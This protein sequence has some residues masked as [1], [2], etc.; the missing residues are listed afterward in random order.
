[1]EGSIPKIML[2]DSFNNLN[3]TVVSNERFKFVGNNKWL[4]NFIYC[5]QGPDER[6]YF[7][8]A[9]PQHMYIKK[10]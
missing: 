1:M 7:K 8:S 10:V 9:N 2:L 6:L 4:G 5:T 3:P